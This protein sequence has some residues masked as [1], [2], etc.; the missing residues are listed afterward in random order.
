MSKFFDHVRE[1]QSEHVAFVEGLC[2]AATLNDKTAV[3]GMSSARGRG[4]SVLRRTELVVTMM[5]SMA[6]LRGIVRAKMWYWW[7]C[8][9]G[10]A[11]W[12]M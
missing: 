10:D 12:R 3:G 4:T 7:S 5:I 2:H 9:H 6:I 8:G 1:N 11:L